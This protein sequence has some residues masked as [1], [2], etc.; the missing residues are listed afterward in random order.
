M[1]QTQSLPIN[2]VSAAATEGSSCSATGLITVK[3]K[4]AGFDLGL[5]WRTLSPKVLWSPENTTP[6]PEGPWAPGP[7]AEQSLVARPG[8][9]FPQVSWSCFLRSAKKPNRT[10]KKTPTK[11]YESTRKPVKISNNKLISIEMGLLLC[12]LPTIYETGR[13][14]G[15]APHPSPSCCWKSFVT[16]KK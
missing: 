9:S 4:P 2:C 12:W 15:P 11:L 16:P 14:P 8:L 3:L 13:V 6:F 10:K 1:S 5:F 7:G